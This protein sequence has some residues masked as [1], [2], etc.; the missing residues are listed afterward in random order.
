[1]LA[2]TNSLWGGANVLYD[3][4]SHD[5]HRLIEDYFEVLIA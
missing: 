3:A 2:V 4:D 5:F 1:M